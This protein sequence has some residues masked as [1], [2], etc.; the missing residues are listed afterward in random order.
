MSQI[1]NIGNVGRFGECYLEFICRLSIEICLISCVA[2]VSLYSQ[3]V[4]DT[5]AIFLEPTTNDAEER[6]LENFSESSD[7]TQISEEMD[8]YRQN[9]VDL[10][11]AS[12]SELENIPGLPPLLSKAI[13]DYRKKNT[14]RSVRDLLKVPGLTREVFVGMKEFV[15]ADPNS[16]SKRYD[17]AYRQRAK[18]NVETSR[19][20]REGRFD[21]NIYQYYQRLN[22]TYYP[23]RSRP[24]AEIRGGVVLEK[25][26]GESKLYDHQVGFIEFNNFPFFKKAVIGNYQLEFGQALSMWG[27]SGMSKGSET[28]GSVKKK[29]RGIRAYNYA[30]ENAGFFGAAVQ[31]DL[32]RVEVLR[33]FDITGFYSYKYFDASY[34]EDGTVNAILTDGF[35][36]TETEITRQDYLLETLGGVNVGYRFGSSNIGVTYYGQQFD[37]RFV[38]NDSIRSL[39]NFAGHTNSVLSIH[40]DLYLGNANFFGEAAR[41]K[42]GNLAYN[43]GVQGYWP[44][45][46]WVVFYRHYAKDFQNRHAYAFGDQNGRSQNEEGVYTGIKLKPRRGTAVHAYYDIYR[47]PWRTYNVPKSVTG[48]DLLARWE[49]RVWPG[50]EMQVQ[51]KNERKDRAAPTQDELGRDIT[52]VEKE[53]TRRLRW[54]FDFAVSSEIRL[55]SR[56]EQSF[57]RIE[58]IAGSYE[59]GIL[60]YEDIRAR[61]RKDVTVYARMS[62]FDTPGF[63]SAIYEFE[64]DVEGVFSNTP[65]SGKGRRWY[66]LLKYA[67]NKR[68]NIGAKYWELYRDDLEHIGSGGDAIRGNVLRKLTF[69][70]DINL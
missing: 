42:H 19:D 18:R 36:R 57:Y 31:A 46:E 1:P 23:M 67:W 38:T 41:D 63:S 17:I 6:W 12:Q 60:F 34:N 27:S 52:V 37:R 54:Q 64:N 15:T 45:I 4:P 61:L 26:P 8:Y 2:A 10:N 20:F 49:E 9:P 58:H 25:D 43:S 68:V 28:V 48:D 22:A 32:S 13:V 66:V 69:S 55:R 50:L 3:E 39:Y 51:F 53:I 11:T 70:A 14:F 29:G 5:S 62:F 33:N 16:R 59:K 44:S 65:L 7:A 24:L 30:T 40:H 21:G 35:H 47:Y 56:F